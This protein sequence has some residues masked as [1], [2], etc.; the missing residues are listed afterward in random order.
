MSFSGTQ[1]DV[2]VKEQSFLTKR[3]T[4]ESSFSLRVDSLTFETDVSA[5]SLTNFLDA[6]T[7]SLC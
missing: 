2:E 6:H 1:L 3:Y 4:E 7:K 5:K